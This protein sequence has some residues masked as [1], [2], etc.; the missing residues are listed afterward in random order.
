M[1]TDE[2]K[3]R[4]IKDWPVPTTVKQLRGFLGLAGYYRKFVRNFDVI[5]KPLSDL[6]RKGVVYVWASVAKQAF[7]ML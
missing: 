5:S 4:A 3:V 6:L 2:S 7:R 1:S